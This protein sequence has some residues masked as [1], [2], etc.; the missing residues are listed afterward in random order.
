MKHSL[1]LPKAAKVDVKY[2]CDKN[3]DALFESAMQRLDQCVS[4]QTISTDRTNS[5]DT[6]C[7]CDLLP[8][9]DGARYLDLVDHFARVLLKI[10]D[11]G[12]LATSKA[13]KKN[14]FTSNQILV[15]SLGATQLAVLELQRREKQ[16]QKTYHNPKTGAKQYAH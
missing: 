13:L 9:I 4:A 6:N 1:D 10:H 7:S 14:G 3:A 15:A 12:K 11:S 16:K 2:H 8:V 5:N